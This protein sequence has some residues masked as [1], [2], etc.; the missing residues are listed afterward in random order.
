MTSKLYP[1]CQDW[2]GFGWI[3][4]IPGGRVRCVGMTGSRVRAE[5]L[6]GGRPRLRVWLDLASVPTLARSL[7]DRGLVI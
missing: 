5:W 3:L 2:R 6:D 7:R 4:A 1:E